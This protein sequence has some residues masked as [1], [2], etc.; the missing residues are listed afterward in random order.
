MLSLM[1]AATSAAA[2]GTGRRGKVRV[3]VGGWESGV[4]SGMGMATIPS[5]K[6]VERS[7]P[8]FPDIGVTRSSLN[9]EIQKVANAMEK[10]GRKIR[11]LD[12]QRQ[13]DK[14]GTTIGGPG[15][16]EIGRQDFCESYI[17]K[18]ILPVPIAEE[19]TFE[20]ETSSAS[21]EQVLDL[22]DSDTDLDATKTILTS[23]QENV[24]WLE[25]AA[26]LLSNKPSAP[27]IVSK[28][29]VQMTFPQLSKSTSTA[30]PACKSVETSA[31]LIS[32]PSSPAVHP[33]TGQS[34][35]TTASRPKTAYNRPKSARFDSIMIQPPSTAANSKAP[36]LTRP[37]IVARPNTA[38]RP[39]SS[40]VRP[41]A[42]VPPQ[43]FDKVAYSVKSPNPPPG[44]PG[45]VDSI[46]VS[47]PSHLPF[48]YYKNRR[49]HSNPIHP[50][51]LVTSDLPLAVT[52]GNPSH[53]QVY[54][55]ESVYMTEFSQKLAIP[56]RYVAAFN[57]AA[58]VNGRP[59]A[60]ALERDTIAAPSSAVSGVS[61][62]GYVLDGGGVSGSYIQRKPTQNVQERNGVG[63]LLC[64]PAAPAHRKPVSRHHLPPPSKGSPA[65]LGPLL[66]SSKVLTSAE[67]QGFQILN[68]AST[69]G[70][71]D[72]A[73]RVVGNVAELCHGIPPVF[74]ADEASNHW[75]ALLILPGPVGR[76]GWNHV[77][78]D[79]LANFHQGVSPVTNYSY[80]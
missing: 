2:W 19:R 54:H 35:L 50:D 70:G 4:P 21:H 27:A 29:K 60:R 75:N 30:D 66:G 10:E 62:I 80:R 61:G 38:T 13:P 18:N 74:S 9:V 73:L 58:R 76:R 42:P 53:P 72:T 24:R 32:K 8:R 17:E 23:E 45:S 43:H 40:R 11:G 14:E 47:D 44:P 20:S 56:A 63:S 51:Y 41:T 55:R 46:V 68:A 39:L 52:H 36:S 31:P 6:E 26:A 48:P 79:H 77:G 65:I 22:T 34:P 49:F 15:D 37:I 71:V 67:W 59:M 69:S 28:T 7:K 78:R 16:K 33:P 5:K 1:Y 3:P 57:V 64:H 25:W 12:S